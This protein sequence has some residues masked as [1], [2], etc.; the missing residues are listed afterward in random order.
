MYNNL[1]TALDL[2]KKNKRGSKVLFVF[3]PL[4]KYIQCA[5][6]LFDHS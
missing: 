4:K 6:S 5:L 2:M 3:T 1:I